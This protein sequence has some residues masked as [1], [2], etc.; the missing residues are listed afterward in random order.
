MDSCG[1]FISFFSAK[2]PGDVKM[3]K[4]KWVKGGYWELKGGNREGKI[5]K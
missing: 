3:V 1:L 5:K 4:R 2:V